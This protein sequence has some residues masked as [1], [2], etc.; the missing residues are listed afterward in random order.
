MDLENLQAGDEIFI[1][2]AEKSKTNLIRT[3]HPKLDFEGQWLT[4]TKINRFSDMPDTFGKPCYEVEATV[5]ASRG[6]PADG[7]LWVP[8][9]DFLMARSVDTHSMG[10]CAYFDNR[11]LPDI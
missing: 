10:L 4:I 7:F 1:R 6:W 5:S 9:S 2:F 8:Y 3:N 11:E